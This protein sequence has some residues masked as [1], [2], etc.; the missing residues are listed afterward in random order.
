[1]QVN[2]GPSP[3]RVGWGSS[4]FVAL[5]FSLDSFLEDDIWTVLLDTA[6]CVRR[7][8]MDGI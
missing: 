7:H 4:L 5:N 6:L 2:E 1:M 8:F 3:L